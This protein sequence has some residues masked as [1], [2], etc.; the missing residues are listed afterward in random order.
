MTNTIKIKQTEIYTATF[1]RL[2]WICHFCGAENITDQRVDDY[3]DLLDPLLIEC[4]VCCKQ[5]EISKSILRAT[6]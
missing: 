6:K 1:H 3:D 4:S 2:E 5:H